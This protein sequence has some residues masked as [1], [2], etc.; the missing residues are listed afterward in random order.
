MSERQKARSTIL[1]F[2]VKSLIVRGWNNTGD[3]AEAGLVKR[4]TRSQLL[5]AMKRLDLT[6]GCRDPGDE[7]SGDHVNRRE[8]GAKVANS[9]I[10]SLGAIKVNER[11]RQQKEGSSPHPS[12]RY[13]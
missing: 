11:D 1:N 6:K 4:G 3:A 5:Q 12:Y 2:R 13:R 8:P 10:R 7:S 9:K